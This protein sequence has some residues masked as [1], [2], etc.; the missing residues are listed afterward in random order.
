MPAELYK[1]G[2]VINLIINISLSIRLAKAASLPSFSNGAAG[3]RMMKNVA[4]QTQAE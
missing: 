2:P 4:I 3:P 1:K